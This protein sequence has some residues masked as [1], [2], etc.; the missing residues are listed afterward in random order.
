M[1]I[2][3]VLTGLDGSGTSSIARL[4]SE[5]DKKSKLYESI[6]VPF[7]NFREIIDSEILDNNIFSHFFFYLSA[8][9]NTSE[10]IKHDLDNGFNVYC[11][12]YL[13]DTIVSHR[14]HGM[15]IEL[16]YS[17]CTYNF[18]KPDF[19]F[20]LEVDEQKRQDRILTRLK[21]KNKLDKS[22][23]DII[24]RNKFLHEFKRYE[25]EIIRISNNDTPQISL[26]SIQSVIN[27]KSEV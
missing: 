22:L 26:E 8:L 15:D 6:L 14:V 17:I 20:F 9:A 21:G 5:H 19:I 10:L 23:D 18:V 16:S 3:S 11:V 4:L 12:R 2:F 27:S 1:A 25:K 24:F 7:S 13:I